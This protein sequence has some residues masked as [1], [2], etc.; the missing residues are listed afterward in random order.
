MNSSVLIPPTPITII[1]FLELHNNKLLTK[2][3]N[4]TPHQSLYTVDHHITAGKIQSPFTK[5]KLVLNYEN[6]KPTKK[7]PNLDRSFNKSNYNDGVEAQPHRIT[8]G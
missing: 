4:K 3:K 1:E 5:K 8:I 7:S 6:F 2:T